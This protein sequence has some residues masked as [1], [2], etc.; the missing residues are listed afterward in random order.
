MFGTIKGVM[1]F[2]RSGRKQEHLILKNAF[3]KFKHN[4]RTTVEFHGQREWGNTED[5][6]NRLA[7]IQ[8]D[9]NHGSYPKQRHQAQQTCPV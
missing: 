4:Y 8:N 1:K 5:L 9:L 3:D 6:K 2:E 7:M